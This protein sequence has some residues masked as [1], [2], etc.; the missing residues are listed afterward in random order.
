MFCG[1]VAGAVTQVI[2]EKSGS[3]N[4]RVHSGITKQVVVVKPSRMGTN[5]WKT[6][7]LAGKRN[8]NQYFGLYSP[9]PPQKHCG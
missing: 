6:A 2:P 1:I 5:R 4:F 3:T 7:S 9:P 8:H